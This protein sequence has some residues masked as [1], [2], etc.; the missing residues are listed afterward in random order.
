MYSEDDENFALKIINQK[1]HASCWKKRSKKWRWHWCIEQLRVISY[2]QQNDNDKKQDAKVRA[3]KLN[4]QEYNRQ[5]DTSVTSATIF[6][7]HSSP[8]LFP[9][10]CS[11]P[12]KNNLFCPSIHQWIVPSFHAQYA[13]SKPTHDEITW[14]LQIAHLMDLWW[15]LLCI[16]NHSVFKQSSSLFFY[17]DLAS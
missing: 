8:A 2:D 6:R 9:H 14:M 10:S 16:A 11:T 12:A 5:V 13:Y 4:R 7:T 17:I 15:R 3:T 1:K